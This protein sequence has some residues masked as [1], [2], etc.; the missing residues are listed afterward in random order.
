MFIDDIHIFIGTIMIKVFLSPFLIL[1]MVETTKLKL[2][3]DNINTEIFK[4]QS[5]YFINF[6]LKANQKNI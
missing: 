1:L 5:P 6:I 4:E 2:D 3:F